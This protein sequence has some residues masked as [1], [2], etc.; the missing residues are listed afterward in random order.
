MGKC[1]ALSVL[2][3]LTSRIMTPTVMPFISYFCRM[4]SRGTYHEPRILWDGELVDDPLEISGVMCP[5]MWAAE[6]LVSGLPSR[7]ACF[8]LEAWLFSVSVRSFRSGDGGSSLKAHFLLGK[9]RE[10]SGAPV[11][12]FA[13]S[14]KILAE[15]RA[16]E[17]VSNTG[18]KGENHHQ[19]AS[20]N[21][22]WLDGG[23]VFGAFDSVSDPNKCIVIA[24]TF[25]PTRSSS[26]QPGAACRDATPVDKISKQLTAPRR[27]QALL[28][29]S[30][31]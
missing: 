9:A 10:A 5:G 23:S 26:M 8:Q 2:L 25:L 13:V 24:C 20:L 7:H 15:R 17:K 11:E 29:L 27:F 22:R 28:L 19:Q 6:R 18:V 3:S 21:K 30:S 31:T 12:M 4:R 1:D 16:Q 14:K